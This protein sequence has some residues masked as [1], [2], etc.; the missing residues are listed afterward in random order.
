MIAHVGGLPFE[1]TIP[2]LAPLV[3]GAVVA[4]R[5]LRERA[6]SWTRSLD[7]RNGNRSEGSPANEG[8]EF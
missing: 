6:R 7:P 4:V 5:L 8:R 2:Q 1:E 3:V